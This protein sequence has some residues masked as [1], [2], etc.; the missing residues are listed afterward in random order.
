MNLKL[1]I[2]VNDID[3]NKPIRIKGRIVQFQLLDRTRVECYVMADATMLTY[4]NDTVFYDSFDVQ[5]NQ[6][7]FDYIKLLTI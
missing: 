4:I 7:F 3:I 2:L 5:N 6:D 1:Q